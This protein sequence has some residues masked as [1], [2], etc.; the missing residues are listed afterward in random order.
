[1]SLFVNSYNTAAENYTDAMLLKIVM[2]NFD[3]RPGVIQRELRLKEP[4][5]KALAAYGHFGRHEDECTWEKIVD[6]SHCKVAGHK[7]PA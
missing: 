2:E 3:F 6:L 1:M 4:R 5:F 7:N